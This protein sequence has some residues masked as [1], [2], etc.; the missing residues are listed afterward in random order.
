MN[1]PPSSKTNDKLL[2]VLDRDGNHYA[3]VFYCP[4]CKAPHQCDNRWAFNGNKEKPTFTGSVLV[5]GE[6]SIGR[7]R[8]HSF[9]A[10]GKIS[11]CQDSTHSMAGTT[12]DLPEWPGWHEA[13]K[14]DV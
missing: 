13:L 2:E 11:Y 7:P 9:V 6:P 8:C 3:W 12:A 1:V 14:D 10:D 5:H 4:A